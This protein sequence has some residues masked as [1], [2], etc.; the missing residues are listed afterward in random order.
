MRSSDSPRRAYVPWSRLWVDVALLGAGGLAM[1]ASLIA[2]LHW[3]GHLTLFARSG[4]VA[5]LTSAIVAYRSLSKHY[6]KMFL[7]PERGK[8][9]PTSRNQQCVDV[10]TLALSVIGTVTWAYADLF[11]GK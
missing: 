1:I 11:L 8:I 6:K 10:A 2:D 3:N 4:A 5:V 9:L 7:L